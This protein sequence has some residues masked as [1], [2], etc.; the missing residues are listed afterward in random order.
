MFFYP[1]LGLGKTKTF[2]SLQ[3]SELLARESY[4]ELKNSFRQTPAVSGFISVI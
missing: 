2:F 4:I 1:F 3:L